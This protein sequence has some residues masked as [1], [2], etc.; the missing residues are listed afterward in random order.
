MGREIERKY[1]LR[2]DG[3]RAGAEG[4]DALLA[5]AHEALSAG[6]VTESLEADAD[7]RF[8]AYATTIDNRTGDSVFVPATPVLAAEPTPASFIH[9]CSRDMVIRQRRYSRASLRPPVATRV[10]YR[11]ITWPKSGMS[12]KLS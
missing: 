2:D 7:A 10:I 5:K 9:A 6:N 11:A 12:R 8:L 1:L 3:W 4:V